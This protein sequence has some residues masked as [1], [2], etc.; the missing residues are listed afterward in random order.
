[1]LLIIMLALFVTA[2][3]ASVSQIQAASP[4]LTVTSVYNIKEPGVTF[5]VNITVTDV[6]DLFMWAVDLSWDPNIIKISTGDPHGL[7]R[8]GIYYNIY[9]GPFLKSVRPTLFLA[10]AIDNTRGNIT[11]LSA[12]Y[13][14]PG[15]AASGSGVLATI[16]FTSINVGTTTIQMTRQGLLID[17]AGKDIP[18]ED[19][20][21]LVTEKEPPPP[22]PVWTELWFQ[23]TAGIIVAVIVVGYIGV[24]VIIP[25]RERAAA[26]EEEI[27]E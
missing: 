13:Q 10:N 15:T 3:L 1:M 16:N 26:K 23:L 7:Y 17:H 2:N 18:H 9:E 4:K 27:V 14:S 5:L 22:P 12:S 8:G 20:N 19:V 11:S 24:K 6:E 25:A 21:G